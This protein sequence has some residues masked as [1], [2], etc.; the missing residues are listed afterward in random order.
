LLN[1]AI[2]LEIGLYSEIDEYVINSSRLKEA[3][4]YDEKITH[5][6]LSRIDIDF[7]AGVK[8][9]YEKVQTG[10]NEKKLIIFGK[11]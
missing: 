2:K 3:K 5:I 10:K 4:E 6:A 8:A 1:I 9:N 11:V 7:D